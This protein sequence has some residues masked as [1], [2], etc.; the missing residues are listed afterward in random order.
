MRLLKGKNVSGIRRR[1]QE[2]D[3]AS[4]QVAAKT[5]LKRSPCSE[6]TLCDTCAESIIYG[7]S[8]SR[9]R[10]MSRTC[11]LITYNMRAIRE[12]GS[13]EATF[14]SEV[15]AHADMLSCERRLERR[16]VRV[17]DTFCEEE[18]PVHADYHCRIKKRFLL[19]FKITRFAAQ[20]AYTSSAAWIIFSEFEKSEASVARIAWQMHLAF[21]CIPRKLS[22]MNAALW[23]L[24]EIN[25]DPGSKETA[26]VDKSPARELDFSRP[27]TPPPPPPELTR[28]RAR[29][30]ERHSARCGAGG[31]VLSLP[32]HQADL[33]PNYKSH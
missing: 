20:S 22:R 29:L 14:G 12:I 19:K 26:L 1:C 21:Y 18:K 4:S 6:K 28:E 33:V 3:D 25:D 31:T 16:A 5:R 11:W 27:I 24:Q 30:K 13:L 23:L 32:D 9:E 8:V 10:S 2:Y 17:L 15:T 7:R